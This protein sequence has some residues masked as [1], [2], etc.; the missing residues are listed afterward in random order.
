MTV[1]NTAVTIPGTMVKLGDPGTTLRGTL[2]A[3]D[4]S[5][6]SVVGLKPKPIPNGT[7]S[8]PF[9]TTIDGRIM[10]A[11]SAAVTIAGTTLRP[12]DAGVSVDGTLLSLE[13]AGRFVVGSKTQTFESESIGLGAA[14][15]GVFSIEGPF[16]SVAATLRGGNATVETGKHNST[17]TGVQVFE[18]KAEDILSSL[19]MREVAAVVVVLVFLLHVQHTGLLRL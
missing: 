7:D 3:A 19:R 12:G 4:T 16:A 17:D 5:G 10:A 1:A 8:G 9:T 14:T 11:T 18:G 2:L 15:T 6:H 13:P